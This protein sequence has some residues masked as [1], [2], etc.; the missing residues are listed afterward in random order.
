MRAKRAKK[1]KEQKLRFE[2]GRAMELKT[3][4]RV[5]VYGYSLKTVTGTK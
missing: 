3:L 4:L 2:N 5:D 1:K